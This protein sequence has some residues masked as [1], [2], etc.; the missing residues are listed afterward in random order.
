M[1][2]WQGFDSHSVEMDKRIDAETAFRWAEIMR[3]VGLVAIGCDHCDGTGT[4]AVEVDGGWATITTER[5]FVRWIK[6]GEDAQ[7]GLNE[8]IR[9]G[10]VEV[11]RAVPRTA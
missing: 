1:S 6:N 4:L 2:R 9:K 3:H 10:L 8:M 5:A 7:G 11:I